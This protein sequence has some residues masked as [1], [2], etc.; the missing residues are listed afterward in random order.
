MADST[1]SCP[2]HG[3]LYGSNPIINNLFWI[4]LGVLLTILIIS[5]IYYLKSG[6]REK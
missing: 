6:K 3:G 5:G 4:T 2:M 1:Y